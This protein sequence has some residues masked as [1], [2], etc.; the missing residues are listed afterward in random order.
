[1]ILLSWVS[2]FKLCLLV[3]II[4]GHCSM[5]KW[6]AIFIIIRIRSKIFYKLLPVDMFVVQMLIF[7]KGCWIIL[8]S[9]NMFYDNFVEYN[10]LDKISSWHNTVLCTYSAIYSKFHV[11]NSISLRHISFTTDWAVN[12]SFWYMKWLIVTVKHLLKYTLGITPSCASALSPGRVTFCKV[13]G[14]IQKNL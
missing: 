11:I 12:V 3:K 14:L 13:N 10:Q 1:M 6:L 7:S 9:Y 5:C 8:V 4:T 2:T